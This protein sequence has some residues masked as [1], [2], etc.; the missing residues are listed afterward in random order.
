M[1]TN[2]GYNKKKISIISTLLWLLIVC[3]FQPSMRE[4]CDYVHV[5][6]KVDTSP[7]SNKNKIL[8]K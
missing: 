7:I 3:I 4:M 1:K 2:I 8:S 6:F 5:Q